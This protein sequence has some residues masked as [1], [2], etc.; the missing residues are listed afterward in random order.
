MAVDLSFLSPPQA[1]RVRWRATDGSEPVLEAQVESVHANRVVVALLAE[2][3]PPPAGAAVVV[4]VGLPDGLHRLSGEVVGELP[5][6]PALVVKVRAV[7]RVQR[8]AFVRVPVDIHTMSAYLIGADGEPTTRFAVRVLDLSGGGMYCECLQA[9]T[10]GDQFGVV[11]RLDDEE[12]VRPLVR[13]VDVR[14]RVVRLPGSQPYRTYLVRGAFE[15]IS[16]RERQRVIQFVYRQQ[17]E[18]RRRGRPE[19]S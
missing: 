2:A 4:E 16:E 8:R 9:L 6:S 17:A 1:A 10:V 12:P 15:A 18:Q 13:V 5:G 19:P 7:E 14:R 3:P 11:L